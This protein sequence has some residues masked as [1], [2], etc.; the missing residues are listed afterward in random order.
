[1]TADTAEV[2]TFAIKEHDGCVMLDPADLIRDFAAAAEAAKIKGWSD[3]L[4][5]ELR[6]GRLPAPHIPPKLPPGFCAVYAFALGA[7][8]GQSAPCGAGR[9]LKVGQVGAGN[10]KRFR[11]SHYRPDGP[12][13]TLARSLVTYPVLWPWLGIHHLDNGTVKPWMLSNLDRM[14]VFVPEG[15]PEVLA[16]IEV[17]ARARIGSVFEGARLNGHR[18]RT[19]VEAMALRLNPNQA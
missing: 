7:R 2:E 19:V 5:D 12:P 3:E 17:Y 4:R 6:H 1:V 9:V 11:Y 15:H 16:A 10:G 13:S 8:A 14:H 18:L